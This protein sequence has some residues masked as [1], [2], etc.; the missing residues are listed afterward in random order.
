MPVPLL[1]TAALFTGLD[2]GPIINVTRAGRVWRGF[3]SVDLVLPGYICFSFCVL[4]LQ[5]PSDVVSQKSDHTAPRRT[6]SAHA[7]SRS[8]CDVVPSVCRGTRV[9]SGA[10]GEG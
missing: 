6:A 7:R 9:P 4:D 3:E 8:M 10:G 1:M 2:L 5:R